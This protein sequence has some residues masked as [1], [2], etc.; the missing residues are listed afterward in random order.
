MVRKLMLIISKKILLNFFFLFKL[1]F[2]IGFFNLY[3]HSLLGA[4]VNITSKTEFNNIL[5][6]SNKIIESKSSSKYSLQLIREKLVGLRIELLSI[7]KRQLKI[8]NNINEQ[9]NAVN[10]PSIDEELISEQFRELKDKLNSDLAEASF[11][12]AYSRSFRER[13]EQYISKIDQILLDRFKTKLLSKG[14]SP[15][16]FIS[17]SIT[18]AELVKIKDDIVKQVDFSFLESINE[19]NESFF[20]PFIL[21]ILGSLFLWSRSFFSRKLKTLINKSPPSNSLMVFSALENINYLLFPLLGLFLIFEG[22]GIISIFGLYNTLFKTYAFV[23][24][25]TFVIS[26][27]LGL[28]L[29][30]KS[31]KI[32]QLFNFNIT[33]EKYFISLVNKLA[34]IFASLLLVD[35]L[36]LGFVLSPNSLANLYF[37]LIVFISIILFSLNRKI[38]NADNNEFTGKSFSL[39]KSFFNKSI[40]LL[41][42]VIPILT[43]FGFLEATLYLIKS[44][45]LS[46]AVLGSAYVLLKVL[47]IFVQS[48]ISFLVSKE[49]NFEYEPKKNL[50]SNILSLIILIISFLILLLVWGF[51]VNN[52]QDLWFKINEGIP[53]GNSSITPSSLA[54][55]LIIFFIGYY[56]TKLLQKI[57]NERVLPATRL[58]AGGKGALLS[59]L[60][61][62]GI[63][64]AALIALSST[65]LD[66]SSLAI[67]AGALSVGLGFGM[68]TIV[69]NFVSGIIML[70]ERPIKEGDWIEVSG[71]S[72]TVKKI[73][74]RSTHLQTFNKATAIIPNSDIISSSVVNWMH[75][76]VDGRVSVPIEVAYDSD[77]EKVKK[78]LL[79]I[80][81]Y[82]PKVMEDPEPIVLLRGFGES[83]I[84]LELRA[85]VNE[86]FSLFIQ[87][88]LNFEVLKKFSENNIEIPFPKRDVSLTVNEVDLKVLKGQK[89]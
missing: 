36:N 13:A 47:D 89:K 42:I 49:H 87:S 77:I 46:I 27:W 53:F 15:L 35:M 32:G 61:Y 40:F 63:F 78:I 50:S 28:S 39:L 16:N 68:Q 56:F 21:I 55:F 33:Q 79:D 23:I 37:P 75:D 34:M 62:V 22:L 70:I 84:K 7:E 86:K 1:L 44:L 20:S 67:L 6:Y 26:N 41:T 74:V 81:K 25:S 59:G 11:P 45:I 17:W 3:A 60:G 31:I 72:G 10:L 43:I 19:N 73:S 57:I 4:E 64:V 30:S 80:A 58:D 9:I 5:N 29:A 18:A 66:L 2:I 24:A 71:Y 85:F 12:L 52:L 14:A 65:G 38:A 83:A 48:T 82:H 8:I 76:E 54:K 88:D 69:S 51:S